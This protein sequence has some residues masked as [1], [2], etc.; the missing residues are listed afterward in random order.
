MKPILLSQKCLIRLWKDF[1]RRLKGFENCNKEQKYALFRGAVDVSLRTLILD[2][3]DIED[4]VLLSIKEAEEICLAMNPS[5]K[6][7][8]LRDSLAKRIAQAKGEF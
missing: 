1:N 2:S 5:P 7:C 4:G 6:D 8:H 3:T